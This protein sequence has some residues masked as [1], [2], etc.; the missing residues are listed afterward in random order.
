MAQGI[1]IAWGMAIASG[2]AIALKLHMASAVSF[3]LHQQPCHPHPRTTRRS[4]P[5]D[6][7]WSELAEQLEEQVHASVSEHILLRV[8]LHVIWHAPYLH[9]VESSIQV[10][11]TGKH[12]QGVQR[13][14]LA[15]RCVAKQANDHCPPQVRHLPEVPRHGCTL[16]RTNP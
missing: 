14:P 12:I 4:H 7:T 1:A 8:H 11:T 13:W 3:L 2:I 10:A 6:T 16:F 9:I 15:L 5:H